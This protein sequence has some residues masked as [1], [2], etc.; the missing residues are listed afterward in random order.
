MTPKQHNTNAAHGKNIYRVSKTRFKRCALNY[1]VCWGS[2]DDA[3]S[4]AVRLAG[5]PGML[6][7]D[8]D[9]EIR[10]YYREPEPYLYITDQKSDKVP[11]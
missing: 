5:S 10:T 1:D 2:I 9:I 4:S 11:K 6:A 7:V 8:I 3:A